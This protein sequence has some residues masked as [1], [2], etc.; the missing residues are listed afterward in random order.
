MLSETRV[1]Y[2]N[3]QEDFL[4]LMKS[5]I[6]QKERVCRSVNGTRSEERLANTCYYK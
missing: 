1:N 2:D 6:S 3:F 4:D 5:R